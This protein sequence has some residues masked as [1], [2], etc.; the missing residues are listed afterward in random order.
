MKLYMPKRTNYINK[1]RSV[2]AFTIIEVIVS[3][4]IS[5]IVISLAYTIFINSETY[6]ENIKRQSSYS[7]QYIDFYSVLKKDINRSN[8]IAFKNNELILKFDNDQVIYI[9]EDEY[10]EREVLNK[11]TNTFDIVIKDIEVKYL[12][13]S[14]FVN[15]IIIQI[16]GVNLFEVNFIKQYSGQSLV[17]AKL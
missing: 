5:S 9:L 17:N 11:R 1:F 12:K 10:V 8:S 7:I 15:E 13:N 4:L 16:Q 6:F 2:N 3:L 14:K